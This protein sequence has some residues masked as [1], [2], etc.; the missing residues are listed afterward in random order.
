MERY[1]TEA[2]ASLL[3][4]I[5]TPLNT[6]L[7][8]THSWAVLCSLQST[9]LLS[10]SKPQGG[11]RRR[12]LKG[13]PVA[14]GAS[15]GRGTL[16]G[17]AGKGGLESG[18][19]PSIHGLCLRWRPQQPGRRVGKSEAGPD[20]GS[21]EACELLCPS[22]ELVAGEGDSHCHVMLLASTPFCW[23]SEGALLPFRPSFHLVC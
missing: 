7:L 16:G 17:L 14:L 8:G 9:F 21:A 20:R 10:L 11:S 2:G 4:S 5:T 15:P 1:G 22:A 13:K 18:H 6:W 23:E 12:E 3:S 19:V